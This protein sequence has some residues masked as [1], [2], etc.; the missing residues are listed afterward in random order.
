MKSNI[1]R[2]RLCQMK[3]GEIFKIQ[4]L[5]SPMSRV[6]ILQIVVLN[7]FLMGLYEYLYIINIY[8]YMYISCSQ[9]LR[10]IKLTNLL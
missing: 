8:L 2:E 5:C 10:I 4:N 9:A 6:G 3:N 1:Y 7:V